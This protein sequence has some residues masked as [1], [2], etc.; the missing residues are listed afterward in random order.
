P[1][2]TDTPPPYIYTLSLHDALPISVPGVNALSGIDETTR[3][4]ER[5]AEIIAWYLEG[6]EAGDEQAPEEILARWPQ[7]EKELK[8]FFENQAFVNAIFSPDD[9]PRS[10]GDDYDVIADIVRG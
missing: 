5:I 6:R 10:F 4:D 7:F 1:P 8:E 2:S 9:R 3:R